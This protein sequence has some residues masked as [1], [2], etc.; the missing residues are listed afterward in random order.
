SGS[1]FYRPGKSW[2][3][4]DGVRAG[5]H[6]AGPSANRKRSRRPY[7]RRSGLRLVSSL[8]ATGGFFTAAAVAFDFVGDL[9]TFVQHAER[10]GFDGRSVDENVLAAVVRLDEAIAL[11]GVVPFDSAGSHFQDSPFE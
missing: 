1:G 7:G 3:S 4:P 10:R 8:K 11:G 2:A 9:L 6:A 5:A